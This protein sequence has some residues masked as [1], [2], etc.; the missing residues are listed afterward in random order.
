[1]IFALFRRKPDDSPARAL[2][3]GVVAAARR[4]EF[5]RELGV[6]DTPVA[7]FELI[8]L[9]AALVM[10]RLRAVDG[11]P[12]IAQGVLDVM[13]EDLEDSLREIGVGDPSVPKRV[14]AL[15]GGFYA[16]AQGLD[17]ALS[18]APDHAALASLV[19]RRVYGVSHELLDDAQDAL[20][21]YVIAAAAALDQQ[22][23]AELAADGPAFPPAPSQTPPEGEFA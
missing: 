16:S 9:H 18:P 6:P 14:K 10:R 5:Y 12:Q 11:G 15:I 17:A 2:Y 1:M 22:S 23:G 8:A 20:A 3:A 13:V 4:P 21:S 19:G 7:R